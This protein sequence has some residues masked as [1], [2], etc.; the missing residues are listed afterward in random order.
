MNNNIA[1]ANTHTFY[2]GRPCRW[3]AATLLLLAGVGSAPPARAASC[4]SAPSGVV[5]WWPGDGNAL[6]IASTNNGTLQGG[7]TD[8]A[9]GEVGQCFSFNGTTSYVSIPDSPALRPTNLTVEAWVLFTSLNSTGNGLAGQ[10]YIV[11]KQNTRSGNFE[12]YYLGKERG[13]GGDHFVFGVSSSAGVGVEA[14]SG[15]VIAT[16]VWYHVA[17]V[18]G[19]NFVQLYLNGQMV[20]QTT[21][22]F[23]QNYGTEPLF[24]GSSG[25]SYWDGKLNGLLDEVSLYNRAL[26]SNEI[27][28]I[29]AAGSAGKC[30]AGQ[31]PAVTVVPGSQSVAQG[32][33]AVFT[34]NASG[35]PPLSFQWQ[36]GGAPIGGATGATLTVSNVQT[37]NAGGY[38]VVVTNSVNSVTSAVATLN[39]LLPPVITSQPTGATSLVGGTVNFT[40]AAGGSLPLNYQWQLNGV[41]VVNNSRISGANSNSLTITN[42]QTGDAGNYVLMVSNGAGATNSA[43]AMLTVNGPPVINAQPVSQVVAPGTLVSFSVAAS[44]TAPLGYQ[45]QFNGVPLSDGGNVSGSATAVLSLS[46]AQ[47][48]NAGSYSVTVTNAIG[49][50]NSMSA[51]L[52]ISVP[53]SCDPAPSGVVSWWP[54]DGNA[55]DIIGGNNGTLQ[56]AAVASAPGVDG[57]AFSFNGTTSYVSIPDSPA[58]RPTNLT[59]EA[60]VLFTSYNS[61]GNGLAGQQYIVFKQ[62][63]RTGN[64]EGYYLGKERGTGGDHFVFGVSSSAGAGAE[65]DSGPIIATNVWYHVAGV[66]GSNYVQL[67]VNGQMVSQAAVAFAQNYGTLPL[68]FGSSGE[69]Y[70]DGK[71]A[72]Y[73]DEVT[74]YNRALA[75][76]EIAAIYAAGS[77]GKC[78]AP[79]APT[80]GGQPASQIITINGTVSFSVVAAGSTPLT[81]QWYKDGVKLADNTDIFGSTAPT[82]TI[83]NLQL[84]DIGN[85]YVIVANSLGSVTSAVASLNTGIPPANDAFAN[86]QAISGSSGSVTGN[87]ANA[88]KESGE[89]NHAG[90]AGGLSVWYSWTAPSASPV[91]FDTCMSAFDTL[92]AV[93]TG[94][95]VNALTP[96]A[97]N[98]DATTNCVRSRLTFTPVAGTVYKIAVDGK[99]GANGNLTLRWAQASVP[100]PDLSL[101]ASAVN[102]AIDTE[103]FAPTSCAV[104]EGLIQAGSRTVIRFSTQTENSGT[105]D[106]IFGNPANN[107]LFVWAP[108]HAHYHFQ[109]YMSYRLLDTN[110][111]RVAVGLK[112]G[113][114]VLDVFRWS[115]SA[116][117]TALYN[118]T[119]QGIQV[120]WGDL[121]DSTLDGQWI[122]ITG[123]PNGNYTMELEANPQGI[124]Q[125]A[126]YSNNVIHVP[127]S[128]GNPTAPPLNDNFASAQALLG[129]FATVP[130]N[131]A[132]ATKE[133]G[134]PNHAG[135]VGGHSVW[136]TWTAPST[137]AVTIDTINSSFNT[138]LAVY[139]GSSLNNLALVASNDDI[140]PGFL[141]SRVTFNATANTTYQIAVDGYNGASGSV[142]LTLNQTLENDNFVNAES[143]GGV[144]GVVYGSTSGATKEPGEPNHA[145]NPGGNSIWYYW[146]APISG[147]ATFNTLGSQFNTLLAVYTGSVVSNL[148]LVASDDDIAPPTN[149]LSSVTFSAIGLTRYDIAIDGYNGA[150]GDSTLNWSLAAGAGPSIAGL[151]PIMVE[152]RLASGFGPEGEFQLEI[153]G[154]PLQ[155]YRIEVSCDLQN[156]V[157]TVT[158]LA[159]EHGYA[160]FTDKTTMRT[161]GQSAVRDVLCGAGQASGLSGPR[162]RFYRA[163]PTSPN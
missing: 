124:I 67:Y 147:T 42:V 12:G 20:A 125:E 10:Q 43:P 90:N 130:G 7:A 152:P 92:L 24:F 51:T 85:Y 143:V 48:N 18:R 26:A 141:Q 99:N 69:S 121:Y 160:S 122:D 1:G 129:G 89:P 103:T 63:T 88:S 162:A 36:F 59:V 11:F 84:T 96:I 87:N 50:T 46:S 101:V 52:G 134:E 76:N 40:A 77:A 73:L 158:T 135:N 93:Y 25:E 140:A 80:I 148:T 74:L 33:N 150:N 47:T 108:C 13:T 131:T 97:S 132:N 31:P 86:A 60:W 123:V 32:G 155:N 113:F 70:W 58:L 66:R 159:D 4:V 126:N 62:N 3:L 53:G 154:L 107:P 115:S 16:N 138:L 78:K 71:L 117:S 27:A 49:T 142:V 65:A 57:P 98:D 133:A 39:V 44:G 22:T 102:P 28:A 145:G 81:Y 116:A 68:F 45:W 79:A 157:P 35:T 2:F 112:V 100:L 163:I 151:S 118:C 105:A 37:A 56:G 29:F 139:T 72:G 94:N 17:G 55:N 75:S 114:C 15:P 19:T 127:I 156:W 30:K 61:T 137:K 109:N 64:F 5:S 104:L 8:T 146:T 111:N 95:A 128:I 91:T 106:M 161:T 38:S 14:D 9:T 6:D 144:S 23:A 21:V 83:Q 34:A 110:G 41:G 149:L 136:Y 120:G 82:I 54:G 119:D 153:A